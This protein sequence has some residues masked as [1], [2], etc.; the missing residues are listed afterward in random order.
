MATLVGLKKYMMSVKMANL[1]NISAYFN[2][3][4]E[5]IRCQ[6]QHWVRKGRV[7]KCAKK[8]ECGTK[9]HGCASIVTEMYEWVPASG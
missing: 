3:D 7:R 1:F 9:C 6:L 5:I 4:P 2:A 8:P